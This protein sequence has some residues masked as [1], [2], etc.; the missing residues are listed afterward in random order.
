MSIVGVYKVPQIDKEKKRIDEL[1]ITKYNTIT[2]KYLDE[3]PMD[4]F[5]HNIKKNINK[6]NSD[7]YY[8]N[9][10]KRFI[11]N[12][13]EDF[14]YS[15]KLDNITMANYE[16]NK[17][18]VT[19]IKIKQLIDLYNKKRKDLYIIN[20][21]D[22][23]KTFNN[24]EDKLF[25]LNYLK[26]LNIRN[27]LSTIRSSI[28][29][30][31]SSSGIITS[32]ILA[33]NNNG[34]SLLVFFSTMGILIFDCMIVANKEKELGFTNIISS[35]KD[36]KLNKHKIKELSK[37]KILDNNSINITQ[38]DKTLE[39]PIK[40]DLN[41]FT[42]YIMKEFSKLLNRINYLNIN[43]KTELLTKVQ[44]LMD[45]YIN[46]Y[47][48]IIYNNRNNSLT[49]NNNDLEKLK[50][51]ITRKISDIES[52]MNN[53]RDKDIKFEQILKEKAILDAR[54][55]DSLNNKEEVSITR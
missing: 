38:F 30:L 46:K 18:N 54:I 41:N 32:F 9:D 3:I 28:V 8:D 27:I 23:G 44:L 16:L 20:H 1:T 37:T 42:N 6:H 14:I 5:L 39:N 7:F 47:K 24:E 53:V 43:N 52:E 45:E 49:L 4:T 19:T 48:E 50:V 55:Q 29:M 36:Y 33:H 25:Y 10:N 40:E 17:Y 21:G 2:G 22:E 13:D 31:L 11:Y 34:Q 26:K 51:Y 35:L 12:D 15:F